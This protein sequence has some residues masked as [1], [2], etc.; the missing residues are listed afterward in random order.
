MVLLSF[1]KAH[2]QAWEKEKKKQASIFVVLIFVWGG[3]LQKN[4]VSKVLSFYLEQT[5]CLRKFPQLFVSVDIDTLG[6]TCPKAPCLNGFLYEF[7]IGILSQEGQIRAPVVWATTL[8]VDSVCSILCLETCKTATQS[9]FIQTFDKW[10]YSDCVPHRL[11]F[12]FSSGSVPKP[13]FSL[14]HLISAL[15]SLLLPFVCHDSVC[16]KAFADFLVCVSHLAYLHNGAWLK[17]AL[18]F[19]N[20]LGHF[21]LL[22]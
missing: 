3:L 7:L 20:L 16:S 14:K 19:V 13:W 1:Y 15:F 21:I 22:E 5:T 6:Q 2:Q 18:K 4:Q 12:C 8:A 11:F 17:Q 9:L 10:P